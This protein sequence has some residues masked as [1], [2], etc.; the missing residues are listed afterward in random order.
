MTIET[1]IGYTVVLKNIEVD[2]PEGINCTENHLQIIDQSFVNDSAEILE[3][4]T[5]DNSSDKIKAI[6]NQIIKELK[7]YLNVMKLQLRSAG[8]NNNYE[9]MKFKAALISEIGKYLNVCSLKC[10]KSVFLINL[11]HYINIQFLNKTSFKL[12][13]VS[14]FIQ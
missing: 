4:F 10:C 11:N 12:G 7:T 3:V 2:I 1:A 8:D 9:T 5:C 14:L 6:D 13:H